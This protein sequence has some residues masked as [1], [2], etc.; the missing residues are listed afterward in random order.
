MLSRT[1][2][3]FGGERD[4]EVDGDGGAADAALG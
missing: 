3:Q 1:P 4:R 2:T